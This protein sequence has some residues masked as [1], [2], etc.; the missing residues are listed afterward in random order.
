V[1]DDVGGHHGSRLLLDGQQRVTLM[2]KV[3]R[4]A[5]PLFF[6]G[7]RSALTGLHFNAETESFGFYAPTKMAGHSTWMQVTELFR[8]G[9]LLSSGLDKEG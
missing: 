4:G 7:A 3:V 1:G 2:Y 8:P 9:R 5:P 6:E